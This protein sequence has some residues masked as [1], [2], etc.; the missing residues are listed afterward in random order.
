[1]TIAG[2]LCFA[3][4]VIAVREPLP[5]P[6][7]GD[8]VVVRDAGANT[9]ALFSRHCSRRAPP[10]FAFASHDQEEHPKGVSVVCVKETESEE[11]VLQFWG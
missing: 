1:M 3:G 11:S 8:R 4:D 10:V 5:W 2:P 6:R 7:L 9:F